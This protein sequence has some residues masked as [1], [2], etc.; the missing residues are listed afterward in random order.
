MIDLQCTPV[1]I[2]KNDPYDNEL[3]ETNQF[4]YDLEVI[5]ELTIG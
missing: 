4:I 1:F 3:I 5:D 2:D